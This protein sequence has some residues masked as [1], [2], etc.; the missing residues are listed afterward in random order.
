LISN[1]G[2]GGEATHTKFKAFDLDAQT[3]N[4]VGDLKH[5]QAISWGVK[6]EKAAFRRKALR[7]VVFPIL[8]PIDFLSRFIKYFTHR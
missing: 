3:G 8:H 2:F 4:F 7:W 1:I 6:D 5:P